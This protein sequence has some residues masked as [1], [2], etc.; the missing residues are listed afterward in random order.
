MTTFQSKPL[1]VAAHIGGLL[2]EVSLCRLLLRLLAVFTGQAGYRGPGTDAGQG[3]Q[4]DAEEPGNPETLLI[5]PHWHG[6]EKVQGEGQ[7]VRTLLLI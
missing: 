3:A 5:R 7:T 2:G 6:P 1:R 4:H